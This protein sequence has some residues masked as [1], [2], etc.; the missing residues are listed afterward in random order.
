MQV[1]KDELLFKRAFVYAADR[2]AAFFRQFFEFGGGRALRF[3]ARVFEFHFLEFVRDDDPFLEEEIL[4]NVG[5]LTVQPGKVDPL[6][7]N[8]LKDPLP[9]RRAIAAYL[10]GRRG[11]VAQRESLLR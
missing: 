8:A 5:R 6:I 7:L 4:A 2:A 9:F 3:F 10:L 11:D 1:S